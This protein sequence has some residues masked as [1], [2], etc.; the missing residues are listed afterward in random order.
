MSAQADYIVEKLTSTTLALKNFGDHQVIRR[1]NT[2]RVVAQFSPVQYDSAY[3]AAAAFNQLEEAQRTLRRLGIS[4]VQDELLK[5]VTAFA[6]EDSQ[7]D[8]KNFA[9][10]KA[11][12]RGLLVEIEEDER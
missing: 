7:C 12:T 5:L 3:T 1:G 6:A 2:H 9:L 8:I 10:L 4:T 11:T